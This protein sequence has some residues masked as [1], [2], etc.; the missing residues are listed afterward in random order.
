MANP[1]TPGDLFF[2]T[3]C[4]LNG[5]LWTYEPALESPTAPD[6]LIDRVGDRAVVEVKHFTSTRQLEQLMA[7]PGKAMFLE[8]TVGKLQSAIREGG[9][10]LSPCASLALPLVVVL[11]RPQVT[12]V[13]FDPDDVVSALLGKTQLIVQLER[14]GLDQ[15]VYS[16]ENAAVLH[17]DSTGGTVNR[18]PRLSAVVAMDGMPQFPRA[19]VY[20]LS[21][22]HGFAGTPL[23]RTMFDAEGDRWLGSLSPAAS[24]AYRMCEK[25]LFEDR[26]EVT[27]RSSTIRQRLIFV[28]ASPRL[29]GGLERW[30]VN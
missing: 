29:A 19:D 17:R 24:V 10:Q 11:S 12:D 25:D 7:A 20:D 9:D 3:Y 14:P 5:Y 1:K 4:D 13:D 15:P 8:S 26:G 22:V 6:Y 21:G 2:E 23:S 28:G 18:L 16:G 27:D 30:V